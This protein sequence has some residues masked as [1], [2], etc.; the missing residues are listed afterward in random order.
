MTTVAPRLLFVS[1]H[2]PPDTSIGSKR[3]HRIAAQMAARGWQ[4]DVLCAH[5]LYQD[6]YDASL[7]AGLESVNIVRTHEL[8]PRAWARWARD[9]ARGGDGT[10]TE[11]TMATGSANR[12]SADIPS[13][14]IPSA[15]ARLRGLMA[16]ARGVLSGGVADWLEFPDQWG[17]WL[18]P[19]IAAA[20]GLPRPDVVLATIPIATSALVAT[21]LAARFD[22]PLVLDYR[23]P[24]NA[25][26]RR[27]HLPPARRQLETRLEALCHSR[28]TALV[29]VTPG[30][31]DEIGGQVGRHVHLVPNACEPERL[32]G[33]TP[34][35]F[36][37]PTMVYAGG[38]YGGRSVSPLLAG[39]ARLRKAGVRN[40]APLGLLVM[41]AENAHVA[42]EAEALGI[43]DLVEVL[44]RQTH[45][46]AMAAA[47][48]AAANLL[49]VAPVHKLQVPAKVFEHIAAGRPIFAL[50]PEGADVD[51]VLADHPAA[52]CARHS[53]AQCFQGLVLVKPVFLFKLRWPNCWLIRKYSM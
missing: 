23:D 37:Q 19:A 17:G 31:V 40:N 1:H 33:I 16:D 4:V 25:A 18:A 3:S 5:Q 6:G 12:P 27:D 8:N 53:D 9:K 21:A 50:S 13:E 2:F 49:V 43:G 26:E 44:P 45:A 28:A 36:A 42:R 34:R 39:L 46:V 48:G 51:R 29:T 35:S 24:W 41:G 10:D 32:V 52:R 38:L 15:D 22:V 7:M 14:D 11:P 20:E 30:L 47:L